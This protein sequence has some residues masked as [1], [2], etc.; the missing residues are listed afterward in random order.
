L[1]RFPKRESEKESGLT[2]GEPSARTIL[3]RDKQ[4]LKENC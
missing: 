2:A 1:R 4:P 3:K